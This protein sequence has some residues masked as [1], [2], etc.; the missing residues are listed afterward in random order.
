METI[1][2]D[3]ATREAREV[4]LIWEDGEN[5]STAQVPE[6][7][8]RVVNVIGGWFWQ[9]LGPDPYA[10]PI[11]EMDKGNRADP[12]GPI[13]GLDRDEAKAA[14]DDAYTFHVGRLARKARG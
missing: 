5:E 13:D 6:G 1:T 2:V 8:V 10:L 11:M 12:F 14:A 3:E 4:T 9:I 7:E